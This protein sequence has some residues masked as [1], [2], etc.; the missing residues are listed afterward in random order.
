MSDPQLQQI[1]L[2]EL[3]GEP[4]VTPAHIGVVVKDGIVTLTGHVAS[5]SEKYAAEEA[6]KRVYG[7]RGIANELDVKLPGSS[8]RTDED[9][10]AAALAALSSNNQVPAD[11]IRISV[12]QGWLKL[13]GEV[14]WQYEKEAAENAVRHLPGIKGISNL[15]TVKPKVAPADLKAIIQQAFLRS[16]ETRARRIIVETHGSKVVLRGRVRSWAERKQAERAAWSAPGVSEVENQL[17]VTEPKPR[18]IVATTVVAVIALVL[19]TLAWPGLFVRDWLR[20][21]TPVPG[22]SGRGSAPQTWPAELHIEAAPSA[23]EANEFRRAVDKRET[24]GPIK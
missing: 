17:L 7:V 6:V 16:A 13:E 15:I 9:I 3:R 1:V 5:Y 18:W 20:S 12:S 2:D 4:S 19:V 22:P 14:E 11:K 23:P 8:Q 24:P 10:A 21:Q